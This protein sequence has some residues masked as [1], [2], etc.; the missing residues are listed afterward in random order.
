MTASDSRNLETTSFFY[1]TNTF[2]SNTRLK[3]AK[4]PANAKQHPGAESLLF[5]NYSD[6]SSML[7]SKSN[8][9][10]CVK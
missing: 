8:S 4:I 5:E 2:K 9:T 3:L 7:S 10:Y 1:I 6:S